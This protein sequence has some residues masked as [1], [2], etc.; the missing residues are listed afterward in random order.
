MAP[1]AATARDQ[2]QTSF[3][4]AVWAAALVGVVAAAPGRAGQAERAEERDARRR[5]QAGQGQD[6]LSRGH[7]EAYRHRPTTPPSRSA[8]APCGSSRMVGRVATA[9][10]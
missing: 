7:A 10:A 6:H 8:S 4:G 5:Q 9:M 1:T 2:S 3:G